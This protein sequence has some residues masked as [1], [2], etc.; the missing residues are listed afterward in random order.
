MSGTVHCERA[1]RSRRGLLCYTIQGKDAA[2]N[3]PVTHPPTQLPMPETE[4]PLAI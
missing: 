3:A 4:I 1:S 2:I